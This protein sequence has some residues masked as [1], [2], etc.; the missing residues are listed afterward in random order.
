M[1]TEQSGIK[2]LIVPAAVLTI[3]ALAAA[4]FLALTNSFTAPLIAEQ[5]DRI[6][7]Q[8]RQ[9][10]MPDASDF[11]EKTGDIEGESFDYLEAQDSSGN[12]IGYL[13]TNQTPGYGGPVEVM[14]GVDTDGVLTGVT[15]IGLAETPGYGMNAAEPEFLEQFEGKSGDITAE[16]SGI[17]GATVTSA[18]FLN[19][20]NQG[21]QQFGS[22]TGQSVGTPDPLQMAFPDAASFS[23]MTVGNVDG[24]DFNYY[25]AFDEAEEVVGYVIEAEGDGYSDTPLKA[26]VGLD[27]E[28]TIV[29]TMAG[30]HSETPGLGSRIEE[31]EFRAQFV[32][33][34]SEIAS[35]DAIGGATKS[36][37]GYLEAVNTAL[38]YLDGVEAPKDP[39]LSVVPEAATLSEE[40]T[41]SADDGEFTYFEALDDAGAVVGYIMESEAD[42]YSDETPIKILVGLDAQGTILGSKVIEHGE[43]PG[44]GSGIEEDTFREQFVGQSG[45]VDSVDAIGGASE[46]SEGYMDAINLALSRFQAIEGG[47]N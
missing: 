15:P 11:V 25:H 8:S 3:I 41:A 47:A 24:Q 30:E 13:F 45:T 36:S 10:V 6:L 16:V 12:L 38:T 14:M 34:S 2:Q 9:V 17:S 33:Q 44:L 43:T 20:V 28:G 39:R 40:M 1:S 35:V 42:G 21:M 26:L 22:I 29:G 32:G 31:E 23:E 4:F 27:L 19:S 37:E 46:S 7:L 5:G 18:A